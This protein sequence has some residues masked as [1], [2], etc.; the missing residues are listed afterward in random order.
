MDLL[1]EVVD[2]GITGELGRMCPGI[3][4]HLAVGTIVV[5][6]E[7][8]RLLGGLVAVEELLEGLRRILGAVNPTRLQETNPQALLLLS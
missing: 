8:L 1:Q 6:E 4:I 7:G 5:G 2:A 3:L